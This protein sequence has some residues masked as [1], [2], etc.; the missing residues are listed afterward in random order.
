VVVTVSDQGPG[1]APEDR[2]RVFQ[3]FYRGSRASVRAAG[4]G[5]GLAI[6]CEIV[7][8]HGGRIW[9]E[10]SPGPGTRVSFSLPVLEEGAGE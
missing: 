9:V 5:M 7:R 2:E 1:I 4:T 10:D 8:L 6:A 3:R